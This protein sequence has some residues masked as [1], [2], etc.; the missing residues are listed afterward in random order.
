MSDMAVELLPRRLFSVEEYHRMAE[1]GLF[2]DERVELLDGIVFRMP[3][4]GIDHCSRHGQVV[5]YLIETLGSFAQVQG[6]ISLPL[7]DRNEPEPDI[8]VLAD[9]PYS[10]RKRVPDPAEI[11]AMI[12]ISNTS[13]T[14]DTGTKRLLY[15]RFEIADYLVVD[16]QDDVLV[17]FSEPLDGDYAKT[18]TMQHDERFL[19]TALP[20]SVLR[21]DGF[22]RKR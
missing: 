20:Y 16:L 5:K 22:L 12:E 11:Y 10:E 9:L 4:L 21:S 3:P 19:L 13:V 15:A 2:E 6:Q 14:R 18:R 17:H 8:A 1:L 7:G